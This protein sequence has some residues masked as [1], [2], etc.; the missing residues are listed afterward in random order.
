MSRTLDRNQSQNRMQGTGFTAV[1]T[2][3]GRAGANRSNRG[4]AVV[5]GGRQR[6]G[7]R[8]GSVAGQARRR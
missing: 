3:K 6:S 7:S 1:L 4:K 2:G 8:A 5:K